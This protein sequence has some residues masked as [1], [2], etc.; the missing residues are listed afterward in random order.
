[1]ALQYLLEQFLTFA[2]TD[3]NSKQVF[4]VSRVILLCESIRIRPYM[5][6]SR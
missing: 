1:M 6:M 3:L 4:K 5:L 2:R